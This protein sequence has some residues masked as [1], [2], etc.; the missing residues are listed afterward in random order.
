MYKVVVHR[1]AAKYLKKLPEKQRSRIKKALT[2]LA[3]DPFKLKGVKTMLGEWEGYRRMRVG[4][5]RI[6][7]WID[8][9]D[10]II[11]IDHLGVR[12]DVYK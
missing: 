12:G 11:Y 3:E 8:K 10:Y 2:Q 1:Q 6:L 5:F 9:E 4:D 7:F